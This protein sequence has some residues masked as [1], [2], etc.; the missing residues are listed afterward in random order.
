[1]L[2]LVVVLG[3]LVA[4]LVIS[5]GGGGTHDNSGGSDGKNPVPSITPGPSSSGPAI[6]QHPGGR[7]ESSDG[8]SSGSAGTAGSSGGDDG[9]AGATGGDGAGGT[10]GGGAQS[11]GGAGGYEVPAGSSLPTCTSG[12]VKLTLRTHSNA[13]GPGEDPRLELT[14]TSSSSADCKIDVGP[15]HTVLTITQA[16][17]DK[18]FWASD[19][20]PSDGGS[21]FLRVPAGTSITHTVT[22]NRKPSAPHCAT[23]PAN[24]AA[25]GTY[26]AE[27]KAPGF[28]KAQTSFV[29]NKD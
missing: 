23:P 24:S 21:L 15:K 5:G 9:S 13:Y 7:D 6:S 18:R 4:W 14:A 12:S 27:A 25:P 22:W 1:M 8:G 19:D 2:S 11:G 17:G 20:C 3:L 28:A 10:G 26:L 16:D 29:L